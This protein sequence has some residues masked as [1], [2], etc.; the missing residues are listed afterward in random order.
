MPRR[1]RAG[2]V[3]DL[4]A[5]LAEPLRGGAR[6][7]AETLSHD[8]LMRLLDG[9][10][11]AG[12]RSLSRTA[13]GKAPKLGKESLAAGVLLRHGVDLFAH[14]PL[15][16]LVAKRLKLEGPARWYSGKVSAL[17]FVR[18]AGFDEAFAGAPAARAPDDVEWLSGAPRW[19][20]S[21]ISRTKY[22][23]SASAN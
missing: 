15:R 7:L 11:L 21:Q 1:K 8:D 14:K 13:L 22:C 12:Y 16:D 20:R 10:L 2:S 23:A 9:G 3:L 18:A 4:A 19:R 6:R 17:R 5:D